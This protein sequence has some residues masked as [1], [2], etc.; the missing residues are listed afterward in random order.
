MRTPKH[1]EP[2]AWMDEKTKY[3]KVYKRTK[4]NDPIKVFYETRIH[5][6]GYNNPVKAVYEDIKEA[7]KALDMYLMRQGKPQLNDTWKL[8]Q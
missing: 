3:Q 6:P 5:V 2:S 4:K 7:A 8:K 1:F